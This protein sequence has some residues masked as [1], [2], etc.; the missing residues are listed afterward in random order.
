MMF[1]LERIMWQMLVKSCS[2]PDFKTWLKNT[3][4]SLST[5][6][7]YSLLLTYLLTK[8]SKLRLRSNVSMNRFLH[9][10]IK[11]VVFRMEC[12]YVHT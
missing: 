2:T 9:L 10:F 3:T 7:I 6:F 4:I 11:Y 8:L 5:P 12:S 1:H